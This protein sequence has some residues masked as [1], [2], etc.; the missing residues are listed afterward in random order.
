MEKI[1]SAF[2]EVRNVKDADPK[3]LY[4]FAEQ[5]R[6]RLCEMLDE[7]GELLLEQYICCLELLNKSAEFK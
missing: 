1:K 3:E 7:E 4:I 6:K 5:C 2:D